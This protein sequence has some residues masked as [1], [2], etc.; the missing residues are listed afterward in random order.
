MR[1]F[2]LL[3]A[4]ATLVAPAAFACQ[5]TQDANQ[6]AMQ[7]LSDH[8][9][10]IVD[11]SVRGYNN[12]NG[13][14]ALQINNVRTGWLTAQNIRAKYSNNDCPVVMSISPM[15]LAVKAESDGSYSVLSQCDQQ[16]AKQAL[17]M[18][19]AQAPKVDPNAP[20]IEPNYPNPA[21]Q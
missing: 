13:Y 1:K 18:P 20:Q 16:A 4:L 8:N 15:T 6:R 2:L 21:A 5:C 9:V 3:T 17:T 10:S 11:F 7:L 12:A 14:A 19:Q